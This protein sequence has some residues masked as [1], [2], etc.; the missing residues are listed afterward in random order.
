[1]QCQRP[2]SESWWLQKRSKEE[3]DCGLWQSSECFPS[4]KSKK[5]CHSLHLRKHH[6]G[7]F[8]SH[9][10]TPVNHPL[11]TGMFHE[12][13]HPAM[14]VS[15][16]W[17]PLWNCHRVPS[18]PMEALQSKTVTAL[19]EDADPPQGPPGNAGKIHGKSSTNNGDSMV[20]SCWFHGDSTNDSMVIQWWFKL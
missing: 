17:K 7:G 4:V 8:L 16:L 10:G 3:E 19:I 11:I 13:N 9:R 14:G 15:H 18:Q 2:P 5:S 6:M 1:M 12:I 20:N